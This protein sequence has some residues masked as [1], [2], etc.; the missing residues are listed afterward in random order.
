M[1]WKLFRAD[2][3]LRESISYSKTVVKTLNWDFDFTFKF[4]IGLSLN[5]MK[6][7]VEPWLNPADLAGYF[8]FG[9]TRSTF[10]GR[11][12]QVGVTISRDVDIPAKTSVEL[13]STIVLSTFVLI[14]NGD[15]EFSAKGNDATEVA[16]YLKNAGITE[17]RLV[18]LND[19][20]VMMK[21]N[22]TIM[23]SAPSSSEFLVVPYNAYK[24][25]AAVRMMEDMKERQEKVKGFGEDELFQFIESHITK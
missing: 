15:A 18:F 22:A 10:N 6:N 12:T 21:S 1:G 17:E 9:Q 23:G 4:K 7:W 8:T 19:K 14:I 16:E 20:V 11:V 3:S 13:V 2:V 25:S 24:G 5:I